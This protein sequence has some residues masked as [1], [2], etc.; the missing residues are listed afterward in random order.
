MLA[1]KRERSSQK[2]L[3][4]DSCS[5]AL[6]FVELTEQLREAQEIS[7]SS[8]GGPT[9]HAV[10][11]PLAVIEHPAAGELPSV[12]QVKLGT[13][14]DVLSK[15]H[16]PTLDPS[17]VQADLVENSAWS[18]TVP[19]EDGEDWLVNAEWWQ[20]QIRMI[21]LKRRPQTASNAAKFHKDG[22]DKQQTPV[23]PP[24]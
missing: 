13:I 8:P 23:S 19:T 16:V 5:V 21:R 10:R 11:A 7:F 22:P 2:T 20:Q 15:K 12:V 18:G 1:A 24:G 14:N 4:F 6:A 17:D 3:M 9:T